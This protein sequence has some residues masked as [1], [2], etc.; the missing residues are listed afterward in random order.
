MNKYIGWVTYLKAF[1]IITVILGHIASPFNAF[2]YSW[3]MPLFFMIAGFFIK[4][5]IELKNLV[6]NDFK[7]LMLPYF[8]FAVIAIIAESIKRVGLHREPLNYLEELYAIVFWMDYKHLINTYAF[9]LWFLPTLFFAKIFY[10]LIK[11]YVSNILLQSCLFVLLFLMSFQ[12]Q[13]PFALSHAM[14][15]CLWIFIGSILFS[16]LNQNSN[17]KLHHYYLTIT[18]LLPVVL[19]VA[20]YDHWG[21]PKLD[22]SSLTYGNKVVN[23]LWAVSL[24]LLFACF[25]KAL[26]GKVKHSWFIEQWGKETMILFILHPYT[27]NISHLIVEKLHIGGW[28]LKLLISLI[29]LQLLLMIKQRFSHQWIFKYV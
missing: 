14:N 11:R 5:E 1:G 18:W 6:I 7:R 10:Y 24:F 15:S 13:L 19:I 20:I 25:F 12:L 27:N 17:V 3:H 9:V 4:S 8:I 2:I 16:I 23:L 26:P 29:L 21:I 28:S 22:M